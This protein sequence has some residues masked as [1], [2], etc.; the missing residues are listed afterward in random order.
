MAPATVAGEFGLGE[1][2]SPTRFDLDG[3]GPVVARGGPFGRR[4]GGP[5]VGCRLGLA[6][7]DHGTERDAGQELAHG[8]R[9]AEP[10]H[11]FACEPAEQE[12]QDEFRDEDRLGRAFAA[13]AAA[14]AVPLPEA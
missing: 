13:G 1:I 10:L 5:D 6:D 7:A 9:L 4:G 11:Q 3:I 14:S 2:R 12:Q 8:R